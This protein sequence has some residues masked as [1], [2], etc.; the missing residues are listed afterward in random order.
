MQFGQ[1]TFD[2]EDFEQHVNNLRGTMFYVCQGSCLCGTVN[3]RGK[4]IYC[5]GDLVPR[6]GELFSESGTTNGRTTPKDL[7]AAQL[8][9]WVFGLIALLIVLLLIRKSISSLREH[10]EKVT[11]RLPWY[12]DDDDLLSNHSTAASPQLHHKD[13]TM[14]SMEG[15]PPSDMDE[16]LTPDTDRLDSPPLPLNIR[17]ATSTLKPGQVSTLK[18]LRVGR[19]DYKKGGDGLRGKNVTEAFRVKDKD[20]KRTMK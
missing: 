13:T 2:G 7:L 16:T 1:N 6:H 4:V 5:Y 18:T 12:H 15:L 17:G 19:K 11:E 8:G 20:L 10:I 3:N 14:E 9:I